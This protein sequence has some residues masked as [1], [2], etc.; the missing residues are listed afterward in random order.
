M[1]RGFGGSA[2]NPPLTKPAGNQSKP[3]KEDSMNFQELKA[4][5]KPTTIKT[6]GGQFASIRGHISTADQKLRDKG[7]I[8]K[9]PATD[10]QYRVATKATKRQIDHDLS[11]IDRATVADLYVM[12]KGKIDDRGIPV[13]VLSAALQII[14]AKAEARQQSTSKGGRPIESIVVAKAENDRPIIRAVK[15]QRSGLWSLQLCNVEQVSTSIVNMTDS[16]IDTLKAERKAERVRLDQACFEGALVQAQKWMA[17]DV[18]TQSLSKVC[19]LINKVMPR[20]VIPIRDLTLITPQKQCN[21]EAV[22]IG[23]YRFTDMIEIV[24]VFCPDLLPL[25]E[26]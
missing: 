10:R 23:G 25:F 3:A 24:A 14:E 2:Q 5:F 1:G 26:Q 18:K 7:T 21:C 6:N 16:E 11:A 15:S 8:S 4:D 20:V 19:A 9:V 12:I 13:T 17:Q 22:A